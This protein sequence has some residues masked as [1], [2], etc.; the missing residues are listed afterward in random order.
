MDSNRTA[1]SLILIYL[2]LLVLPLVI[3]TAYSLPPPDLFA[4]NLGR[5]FALAAF[6]IMALQ[7]PLASRLKW[8]ERPFGLNLIFPFHRNMAILAALLLL[9]HP[10]LMACGGGGWKLI[11]GDNTWYIWVG[12]L[13]LVTVLMSVVVSLGRLR[14]GVPFETWRLGHNISGPAILV[15]GLVHSWNASVDFTLPSMRVLWVALLVQAG[16]FYW[17]HRFSL[18][19]RLRRHPYRVV[20]VRQES[21]DVWT[22]K[23]AP[24]AGQSRFDFL[25][26]Q[27]QFVTLLRGRGLPEEEHHFTISSSPAEQG[28]HSST[29]KAS[30]DFTATI[31][32]TRPGDLAVIEAPFGRFSYVHF[33][34]ATD[35][36]FI[37]GGIGITPFMSNLQHMHNVQAERR[38]LL[39]WANKTG[40]DIIFR[41]EL[42]VLEKGARPELKVVHI[43]SRPE[44]G[45]QGEKGHLDREAVQRLAGDRL[46]NSRFFLCCPPPLA[47]SLLRILPGLGVPEERISL[48]Y[49]SL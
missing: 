2:F 30:G 7:F 37:A 22:L 11:W 31:G 16:T 42:A 44:A 49:F 5:A 38:V 29:I 45:W 36:V 28:F 20:D 24:P 23:F 46:A 48:E 41:E 9:A 17:Y 32:E 14:L 6:V 25:P 18:P 12:R 34:A 19:A 4:Y 3:V 40:A 33:P 15:L 35:L 10:F 1:L 8:I 47:K 27:F 43:L 13:A 39:L 21:H 26:G